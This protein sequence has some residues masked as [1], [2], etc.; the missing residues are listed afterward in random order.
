MHKPNVLYILADDMGWGDVGFHGSPIKTPNIDRLSRTGVTLNQHYVCPV[1]TPTRV[2]L[3]T[4]RHPGRFGDKATVPCN[5]PVLP[6]G[7][8]TLASVLSDSG[9]AC[10]LFGKWHLGS[11]AQFGPNHYG[12]SYAYGSLA[13]GVDAYNHHY[14]RGEYS[15]TWHRNGELID[16]TG[17]VT[18]LITAEAAKWIENQTGPWFCY[19]PFTAV[20]TPIKPPQSWL[21]QYEDIHFD[22]DKG[23]DESFRKY[24]A[25]ASHMDACVGALVES[26]Y[27]IGKESETLIIFSSDNGAPSHSTLGDSG[28]YPGYQEDNP[29][30]GSNG[31]LRGWKG[32]VYEGGIRTPT[33]LQ[34]IG[35]LRPSFVDEP[36]SVTD[37]LPTIS[38]LCSAPLLDDV[39]GDIDGVDIWGLISGSTGRARE[40]SF[41]WNVRNRRFAVRKGDWK[42]AIPDTDAEPELY[43]LK[44]DPHEANNRAREQETIVA[45][46]L[47]ELEKHRAK[48]N[49]FARE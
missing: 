10:G 18:D 14:K 2:S 29:R 9:Y 38:T 13:G 22:D 49:S 28:L 15:R 32:Q 11:S 8:K 7:Y 21:S 12:F 23:R 6:D 19:V 33:V 39:A 47:K 34:W 1:C 31:S 43:D 42:L 4:G 48:D 45:D 37:W 44:R 25:Y 46:L 3:L 26:V 20:H 40:R 35:T 41:Y 30:L 36:V 16:E 24:A 5:E 27:R 17:H